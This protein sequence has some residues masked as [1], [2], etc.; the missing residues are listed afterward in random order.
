MPPPGC[1]P[2]GARLGSRHLGGQRVR[3]GRGS[4]EPDCAERL[5]REHDS[6]SPSPYLDKRHWISVGA[7]PDVTK[8]LVEELV[9]DSYD[10][11]AADPR[12]RYERAW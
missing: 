3:P 4:G 11:A 5:Y 7:G 2:P 6:I 1:A 10:L 8:R 12:S 9:H